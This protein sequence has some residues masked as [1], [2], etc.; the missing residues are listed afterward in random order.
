MRFRPLMTAAAVML[1]GASPAPAEARDRAP[2]GAT[3]STS[4]GESAASAQLDAL[5]DAFE[6]ARSAEA[7]PKALAIVDF[8]ERNFDRLGERTR[9]PLSYTI[10]LYLDLDRYTQADRTRVTDAMRKAAEAARARR[11]HEAELFFLDWLDLGLTTDERLG[12]ARLVHRRAAQTGLLGGPAAFG[13]RVAMHIYGSDLIQK[14]RED[15]VVR[16]LDDT[17][18]EL[19][20]AGLRYSYDDLVRTYA[21]ALTLVRRDEQAD[22]EFAALIELYRASADSSTRDRDIQLAHNQAAYYRNIVGRFA[23]A[24]APGR[25]A[26]LEAERLMGRAHINTQKAR[27]NYALALL[28]Q[29]KAG[30]ALPYFEEA[31]PLQ[32]EAEND[33]WSSRKSDTIILLTTLA[34]ARAQVPGQEAAGLDAAGEAA[35]R[36]R[37]MRKARLGGSD[38]ADPGV[39]ALAKAV[40]QGDR[41]DPLA[42]AFDMVLFAA[43]SARAAGERE[44]EDAFLAAQDLTLTDA[45]DAI[46]EAAAREIAGAG[47]LGALVRA[48]QDTAAA[49]VRLNQ[50]YRRLSLGS[51]EA[52][53]AATRAELDRLA[54][55]LAA[56]DRQL[57][58]DFP[59]YATLTAPAGVD[60]AGVQALL[61]PDEAVLLT[62][63][64]EGHVYVFGISRGK[65]RWHRLDG[66]AAVVKALVERLKCRID[67]ATCSVEEY[68]AALGAEARTGA[69]P[70]DQHYPRYD[71]AAAFELYSR[72][73]AP[74]AAALP[75]GARVYSVASGPIAGL[76]LAALVRSAPAGDPEAGTLEALQATDWLADHYRFVTLPSISALALAQK[77]RPAEAAGQRPPLV[78]Y[79]APK[80]VGSGN[81]GA[82]GAAGE[83]RRGGVG[84]R[85]AGL[86][87]AQGD[88]TMAS[89]D[90]LRRLDPLPGTVTELSRL[91][92][93]IAEGGGLRLGTAATEKA[94]KADAELP[95]ARAVVFATHGLLP[96]EMGI[97]SEPGLVLT[98]PRQPSLGDDGLLTASEAAALSLSARW[99]VLSACN[100]A[101]PAPSGEGLTTGGES[102]SGLARS[103]LYAGAGNLLASHWR[104]ADDAT[105]ALTVETLSENDETPAAA[106]ARAMRAVRRGYRADGSALPGWAP[107]WAHPASWAPFTLITNRDR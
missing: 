101:T 55:E 13:A 5:V 104:V 75:E 24:E 31:L 76:P 105:A 17:F 94:V 4:A 89:V 8:V 12:H 29:G 71:R 3:P 6:A 79:G 62:L 82:R 38:Q 61:A 97:G 28:G 107:H 74:V 33:P 42:R 44:L 11:H 10:W 92:S 51:D 72:L 64:S 99:V 1:L 19:D 54:A 95:M 56:Q 102:L 27:Y 80:L 26:A 45:G 93:A 77:A 68:N 98:P 30:E 91:S 78:A 88:R 69:T 58:A 83:R 60:L 70:I 23:A 47:P 73:I 96:G 34:R 14:G 39:A 87:L 66:G 7:V 57:A 9:S 2:T 43:W 86:T 36:L 40:A 46:N 32:L 81:S 22:A 85:S 25:H 20:A 18:A 21:E 37:E 59:D 16:A 103:F 49:V 35:R 65:A 41:R 67:E 53:A 90:K 15:E 52:K 63:P 50:D 106:L 84:V 100:T 48:R